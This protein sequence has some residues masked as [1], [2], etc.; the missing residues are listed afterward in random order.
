[1]MASQ[2][3]SFASRVIPYGLNTAFSVFVVF[4]FFATCRTQ[5]SVR[6][7]I[8]DP[9]WRPRSGVPRSHGCALERAAAPICREAGTRVTT[10]TLVID[11]NIPNVNRV[12][13]RRIEVIANGL[14]IFQGAQLAIDTTLVSLSPVMAHPGVV[15]DSTQGQ[16]WPKHSKPKSGDSRNFYTRAA[17]ASS[18]WQL[19]LEAD[20][21]TRQLSSCERWHMHEPDPSPQP[22]SKQPSW[23]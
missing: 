11:F 22:C 7:R 4:D 10:N 3:G 2:S 14:P 23:P 8:L 19:K 1:M 12:D 13:N 5:L 15:Q 18:F 21:A 6:R 16:H 9:S 20:S 17:A